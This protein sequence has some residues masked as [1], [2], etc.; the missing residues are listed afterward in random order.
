MD[1]YQRVMEDDLRS[2][3][4]QPFVL[5]SEQDYQGEDGSFTALVNI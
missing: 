4:W 5:D 2:R 1:G 3:C